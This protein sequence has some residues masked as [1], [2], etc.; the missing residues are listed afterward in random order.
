MKPKTTE[1][2]QSKIK[3]WVKGLLKNKGF[4]N[5]RLTFKGDV[6]S[7]SAEIGKYGRYKIR[8]TKKY[9]SFWTPWD[10]ADVVQEL[11]TIA[12][13]LATGALK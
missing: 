4:K 7:L 11:E 5:P 10:A 13:K 2:E 9:E 1:L 8:H 12:I 3:P 6:L